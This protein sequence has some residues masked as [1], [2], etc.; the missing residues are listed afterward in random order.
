M[1]PLDPKRDQFELVIDTQPRCGVNSLDA[2]ERC[3]DVCQHSGDCTSGMYCYT[4]HPNVSHPLF[5]YRTYVVGIEHTGLSHYG[6]PS[7]SA[8]LY[9]NAHIQTPP[10]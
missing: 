6:H 2:Q 10:R 1:P 9:R 5:S 3:G 4:V 8:D 7:S